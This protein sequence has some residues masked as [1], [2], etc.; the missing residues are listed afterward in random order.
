MDLLRLRIFVAIAESGS[1]TEAANRVHLSQPAVSRNLR[2]MEENLGVEL[3]DRVGRG[4]TLNAAGRALLPR[5]RKILDAVDDAKRTTK[6]A[7]ERDF[8]DLRVG[9][10]D[11]VA[12]YL[13]PEIVP[14][15]RETFP[16][17][18]LK[19]YTE[20]TNALLDDVRDDA[21][22]AVV[23]AHSGDPPVEHT[24]EIGRYDLQFYGRRDRFP[25][26]EAVED[27]QQLREYPIVQLTPKPGQ[28][29]LIRD[30]TTS[31]ALAGSL[32]TI[33]AL[34]LGG[35]GV[36]SLLHFMVDDDE[37][38]QLVRASV[39]HDPDCGLYLARSPAW[40]GE[41]ESA[42]LETLADALRANYPEPPDS[43]GS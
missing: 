27:E 17:L 26:L 28:P 41:A 5:A 29:T 36:G 2:L 6:D 23:V 31:F 30:D 42:I 18:E 32:A 16:E 38:E 20:R 1:A 7:A 25:D 10:V 33:K 19:F 40:E 43:P 15:L 21:L 34:V 22:D 39:P 37:R 35:F 24:R 11:S 14:E 13:F 12:T 3:F 8:F 9:T 4:L